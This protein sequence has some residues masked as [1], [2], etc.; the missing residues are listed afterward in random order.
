MFNK[1]KTIKNEC[2]LT[3]S[4]KRKGYD[5]WWHS[6]TG[7]DAETNE[8][9]PFFLEFFLTNPKKA[10]DHPTY[11]QLGEIPSY[12]MVKIGTWGK[13]KTQVHNFYAWKD[14]DVRYRAPFHVKAG[15]CFLTETR[16]YG[17]A[18]V[19]EEEAAEHPE[20]MCSA[21]EFE[22]NLQIEKKIAFNVGYG[23]SRLCRFLKAFEMYWHA[24][25]MKT[26]FDGYVIYNG[27][28][29]IVSRENC[30]G[31]AD[32]NWGRNFTTPWIWLSSNNLYSNVHKKKL[33]NSVFDIGGGK[34]K[35][36]FIS[37]PR[38]LLGAFYYEGEEFEY[39]FSKF[40]TFPKTKF[41]VEITDEQVIWH[42]TQSR[43]KSRM[44]VNI[45]CQKEDMLLVNYE[46]PDGKKRHN[47]LWNGGNGKGN[48]KLYKRVKG[49][50]EL[51]DDIDAF[52]IGCEFGEYDPE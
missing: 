19:T 28:K 2:M 29:Y 35:V 24:E 41:D 10:Q 3:G 49:K 17:K 6:F 12:L 51:V 43:R 15:E 11:G 32:K 13:N 5:W 16:T 31:Y 46:S 47:N 52:N 37:I 45:T 20:Y 22:W 40:W 48:I 8:E 39:N 4:F 9:K 25:G 1:R 38:Q 7:R 44:E 14:V 36:Y 34:P 33:E 50:M 23:T 27:R 42:I 18:K 26:F 30:Y 21:G